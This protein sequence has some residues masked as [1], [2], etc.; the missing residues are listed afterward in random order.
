[1][2]LFGP[3][4]CLYFSQSLRGAMVFNY[5]QRQQGEITIKLTYHASDCNPHEENNKPTLPFQT[6]I[7]SPSPTSLTAS[8]NAMRE[9]RL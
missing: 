1:M 6:L 7:D 2:F 9:A 4:A 5:M 3:H 8:R